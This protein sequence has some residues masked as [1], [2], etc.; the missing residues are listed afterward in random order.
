MARPYTCT[1][2]NQ[3]RETLTTKGR[4]PKVCPSCRGADH[5]YSLAGSDASPVT[6][7]PTPAAVKRTP[8]NSAPGRAPVAQVVSGPVTVEGK[9]RADLA[10]MAQQ[11]SPVAETLST[12]ALFLAQ[13]VDALPVDKIRERIAAMRQLQRMLDSITK[14][15]EKAQASAPPEAEADDNLFGEIA[16][17]IVTTSA[18]SP[19]DPCQP[20]VSTPRRYERP[21]WGP[22]WGRVAAALGTPYMPWQQ[23]MANLAGEVNE[24]GRLCYNEVIVTVPRQSGKT[25]LVLPVVVGRAEAGE[26][27]G[28]R[29][30]MVYAA[31]NRQSAAKKFVREYMNSVESAKV[32]KGRFKKRIA[33]G[34]ESLT[35]HRSASVFAVIATKEESG[36][37]D[38]LD[39]GA[40]DE[41]FNQED[42]RV[43][44]AW[45]PAMS[46]RPMAQIWIYSTM[47]DVKAIWFASQIKRAREAAKENSGFGTCYAEY[48]APEDTPASEY[49][50]P[51]LW[52]R[53]MPA[54]GRTQ[55]EEFIRSEYETMPLNDFRRAYL[56]Q[57]VDA[58]TDQILDA[59][60]WAL[61]A[62]TDE[63]AVRATRPILVY[64]VAYDRRFS[65]ILI[66]FELEDGTPAFKVAE[67]G[68]GTSWVT[69]A[70]LRLREELDPVEIVADSVGPS[71]SITEELKAE[72]V[73]VRTSTTNEYTA[74]CGMAFDGV[75][76][77]AFVHYDERVMNKAVQGAGQR[78]LGDA[79]AWTRK[80]SHRDAGT[81]ISPLVA[82]TLGLWAQTMMGEH[83]G[84]SWEGSFG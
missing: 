51:D 84:H 30:N 42:N 69:E 73:D 80:N 13:S 10:M 24:R 15:A 54:L 77:Q 4:L 72:Y 35:F 2:C 6:R 1:V 82:L 55:T 62:R 33:T 58:S 7:R 52:R 34:S 81:D 23:E 37:G 22:F 79:W 48:G 75:V 19:D 12:M 27:F 32:M 56:N 40:L 65:T 11:G 26:P 66:A 16:A 18:I 21:T 44:A 39:F 67:H 50:N 45:R 53:V 68:P 25:T 71:T 83:A 9:L 74:A 5:R 78:E 57:E 3:E 70:V 46:T 49:G 36:H 29:Q 64:D 20:L 17:E 31:Q 14:A 41:A 8:F 63:T 61:M 38:V 59:E 47:G 43:K 76:N 28:G 60:N